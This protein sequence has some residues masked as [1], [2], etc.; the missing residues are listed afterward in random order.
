M[1]Q[2]CGIYTGQQQTL[3]FSFIGTYILQCREATTLSKW[4]KSIHTLQLLLLSLLLLWLC[5][6]K[7]DT[8]LTLFSKSPYYNNRTR[9][10]SVWVPYYTNIMHLLKPSMKLLCMYII[11][12]C[13]QDHK[14]HT[15]V[16][17]YFLNP[18]PL[19]HLNHAGNKLLTTN[20][21]V[22]TISITIGLFYLIVNLY[23]TY[24]YICTYAFFKLFSHF[25]HSLLSLVQGYVTDVSSQWMQYE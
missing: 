12:I 13:Q 7:C 9:T 6:T 17:K 22:L 18:E 5:G 2:Y 20:Q 19:S 14:N 16:V 3:C 11:I 1:C 4:R 23:Y 24:C 21:S 8:S 25:N 15:S 10:E